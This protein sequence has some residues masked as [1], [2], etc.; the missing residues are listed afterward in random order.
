[1]FSA[2]GG[3]SREIGSD[4]F[5]CERGQNNS[6]Y[7]HGAGWRMTL[8]CVEFV[9]L[10]MNEANLCNGYPALGKFFHNFPLRNGTRISP[11]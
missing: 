3:Q 5:M 2:G 6:S 1:M 8:P 10:S 7:Y 9:S 4:K 11:T